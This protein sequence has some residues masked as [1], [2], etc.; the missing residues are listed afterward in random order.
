[1]VKQNLTFPFKFVCF[2]DDAEGIIS[3]VEIKQ[4]SYI[5][6]NP[7]EPERGWKKLTLFSEALEDL[8]GD[9]LYLDI[10]SVIIDNIDELF[11]YQKDESNFVIIKDAFYPNDIIGASAV[12]RF[13]I[14]AYPEVLN[15]FL[16]HDAE[17]KKKYRN[18]QA[19]LSYKIAEIDKLTYWPEHWCIN[20]KWYCLPKWPIRYFKQP[21]KPVNSKIIVFSGHPTPEEAYCGYVPLKSLNHGKFCKSTPWLEK[22]L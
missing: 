10:D 15:Y 14:G 13:K 18:E 3:D 5:N 4:I 20:F 11:T 19:Y 17:I 21:I 22:Y 7:N 6:I 9:A 1:M 8:D 2:T 12:F 16:K